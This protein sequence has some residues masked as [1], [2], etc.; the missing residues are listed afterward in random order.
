MRVLYLTFDFLPQDT[1]GM[2]ICTDFEC[3]SLVRSGHQVAVLSELLPIKSDILYLANR[4]KSF[5][6]RDPTPVDHSL[7]YPVYRGINAANNLTRIIDLWKPDILVAHPNGLR[8]FA[9][10]NKSL[11]LERNIPII[12]YVH[13]LQAL[14]R[15]KYTIDKS[16]VHNLNILTNS[17]FMSHELKKRLDLDYKPKVI[18]P[19]V[20]PNSYKTET[21]RKKVVFINPVPQKG[22]DTAF[23]LAEK[24]PDIPFLF[25]EGWNTSQKL[26]D[27]VTQRCALLNNIELQPRTQNMRKVYSKAKIILAPTPKKEGFFI[28]AWGRIATEAHISGIPV[29]ATGKCGFD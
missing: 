8:R 27:E 7:G 22:S 28:E 25:V 23:A 24:C 18:F 3:T 12:L 20:S 29:I 1:S 11:C 26:H 21:S 5:F 2:N 10:E 19:I 15:E 4:F 16:F 9:F 14:W 13:S 6:L 17:S